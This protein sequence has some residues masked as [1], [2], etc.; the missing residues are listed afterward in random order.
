MGIAGL[1][2]NAHCGIGIVLS[3]VGAA[4]GFVAPDRANRDNQPRGLAISGAA[5]G[6][7]GI[8]SWLAVMIVAGGLLGAGVH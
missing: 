5:L 3:L 4:M 2:L 6:C 8:A 7:A 1:L